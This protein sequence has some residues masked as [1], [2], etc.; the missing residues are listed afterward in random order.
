MKLAYPLLVNNPTKHE[1]YKTLVELSVLTT[2]D[3][4]FGY[5]TELADE[6]TITETFDPLTDYPNE[7]P[8]N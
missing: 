4:Y 2:H 8:F 7:F 1:Y 3:Y 5:L 6:L